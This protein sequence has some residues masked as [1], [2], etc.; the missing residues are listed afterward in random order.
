MIS[1]AAVLKVSCEG[2][3]TPTDFFSPLAKITVWLT[4]LPSKNTL[5]WVA[6]LAP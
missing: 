5:A 1:A 2:S 3:T 4:H 6:M